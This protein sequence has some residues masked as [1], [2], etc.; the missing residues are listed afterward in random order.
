MVITHHT[1]LHAL[2]HHLP[3]PYSHAEALRRLPHGHHRERKKIRFAGFGAVATAIEPGGL[4]TEM[5]PPPPATPAGIGHF[6]DMANK[7]TNAKAV[8]LAVD[9]FQALSLCIMHVW[10]QRAF[11]DEPVLEE[12]A[13]SP[14]CLVETVECRLHGA[15]T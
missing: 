15:S 6:L 3:E 12:Y 7:Q 14:P 4:D 8:T 2:P 1:L 9:L 13:V 10:R 11:V 5:S